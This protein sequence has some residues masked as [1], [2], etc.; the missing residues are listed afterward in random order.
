MGGRY[1][2]DQTFYIIHTFLNDK[3]LTL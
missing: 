3:A 2:F 1:I